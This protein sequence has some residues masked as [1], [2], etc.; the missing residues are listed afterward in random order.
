MTLPLSLRPRAAALAAL[1]LLAG[2]DAATTDG[3][4]LAPATFQTD[5]ED[6]ARV[7]AGALA[8]DRGGVLEDAAAAAAVA[9]AAAGGFPARPGCSPVRTFDAAAVLYTLT[10][11]CARTNTA[12]G[13]TA[14]FA[15]V[16]TVQFLAPGGQPQPEPQGAT[17][18]AFDVLSGTSAVVTP[19]RSHRL[20]SLTASFDVTGLGDSLVTVNGTSRRVAADTLTTPR[21]GRRTLATEIDLTLTDVRGPRGV[22]A[23]WH[24][25]VSGTVSGTVRAVRTATAPDGTTTTRDVTRTFTVTL[26][27]GSDVAEI[28]INGRTF[29]AGRR[30]GDVADI[31]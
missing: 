8:L 17:A 21:G 9:A 7:V 6:A 23:D 3:G 15:R 28:A 31:E 20:L 16:A 10:T 25:A 29:R 19:R 2:C 24:R 14:T 5:T 26:G 27:R 22:R 11:D 12:T 18:L 30:T 13:V 4:G 1:V